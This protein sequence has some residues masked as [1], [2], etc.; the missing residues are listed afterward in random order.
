[1][2]SHAGTVVVG[3]FLP[4]KEAAVVEELG[5]QH[6]SSAADPN[7]TFEQGKPLCMPILLTHRVIYIVCLQMYHAFTYRIWIELYMH[8]NGLPFHIIL[9]I[10][11]CRL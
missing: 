8:Y 7:L 2:S 6:K 9:V 1:M 4:K 3:G 11:F 5:G 10:P